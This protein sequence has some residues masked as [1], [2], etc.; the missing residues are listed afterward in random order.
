MADF[1]PPPKFKPYPKQAETD[2]AEKEKKG[3]KDKEKLTMMESKPSMLSKLTSCYHHRIKHTIK[4]DEKFSKKKK[5]LLWLLAVGLVAMIILILLLAMLLHRKGDSMLVQTQW[6]NITGYPPIPTGVSTIVQPNAVDEVAGCVSVPDMWS[7]ALPKE[8]Q[9]SF[10]LGAADQPNFRVEIRFENG[11]NATSSINSS[12]TNKRSDSVINPVSAASF[13]RRRL[14]QLRD[15]LPSSLFTPSPSP[16]TQEDETFLGNTTDGN[17]APFDGEYTPFF[18]TFDSPAPLPSA[19]RLVKRDTTTSS[20]TTTSKMAANTSDPFPDLASAIPAASTNRNGTASPAN[21]YPFPSAQPLRLFDR[22]LS[23]EHYGF[24]TYFDRSIFLKST[25]FFNGSTID[26]PDDANGG[27]L[28]DSAKVR[29]TW[30]ET[31]FLVQIWTNKGN[32]YPLLPENGNATAQQSALTGRNAT[33]LAN[34]S[35]NDLSRP[36]SFPYPVTITLDRHGGNIKTKEIYCYGLDD[37]E[38]PENGE[39]KIQLEDRGYRGTPVNPASGPFGTNKVSLAD[40]G[41]G[42]IDGGSGGCSCKWQNWK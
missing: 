12:T 1:F 7:C 5:R 2:K 42:G 9:Q 17:H 31:R 41:P 28:E 10:S 20:P 22:G 19:S 26:V 35:A 8:Q 18:M 37:S 24:F 6:L 14:L 29:C 38:R 30:A 36:G 32:S 33:S 23:T 3:D 16:P 25:G 15:S 34:S 11:T 39:K 40:G 27:A 4:M 21:L 13:M